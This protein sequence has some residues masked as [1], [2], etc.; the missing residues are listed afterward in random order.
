MFKFIGIYLGSLCG[1]SILHGKIELIKRHGLSKIIRIFFSV[2]FI[3]KTYIG[4]ITVLKMFFG[5]V[6]CRTA[7]QDKITHRHILSA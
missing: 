5:K 2:K 7:A 1:G 6:C 3:V 4:N